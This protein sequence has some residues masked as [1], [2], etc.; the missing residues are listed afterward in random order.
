MGREPGY[1]TPCFILTHY[2]RP[3]I[4]LEGGTTFHFLDASPADAL[5]VAREA[6]GDL[7][8]R[9]GGG[10]STLRAFLEADLVDYLDLVIIP[11][12][13]GGGIRMWEGLDRLEERFH[14]ESLTMPSGA[15]HVTLSR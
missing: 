15:T 12:V 5:A 8:V 4:T 9:I 2:P 7:D 11:I 14:V 6:A 3:S 13:I 10:P 1:H